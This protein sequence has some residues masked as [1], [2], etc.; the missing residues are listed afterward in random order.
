MFEAEFKT[1]SSIVEALADRWP[2]TGVALFDANGQFISTA[3]D[4][5][6][7]NGLD[8]VVWDDLRKHRD[9]LEESGVAVDTLQTTL[10]TC[11]VAAKGRFILVVSGSDSTDFR[12]EAE[13]REQIRAASDEIDRIF[14]S[15]KGKAG[16]GS[17]STMRG[18]SGGSPGSPVHAEAIAQLPVEDDD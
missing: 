4:G 16:S 2:G 11:I 14:V 1:I 17:G 7:L 10:G 6:R 9:R 18:G 13:R 5:E 12:T 3:G 15:M 8:T